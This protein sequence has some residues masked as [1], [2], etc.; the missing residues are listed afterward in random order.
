M[1]RWRFLVASEAVGDL[2][3]FVESFSRLK[4]G[5]EGARKIYARRYDRQG[6]HVSVTALLLW[7][8]AAA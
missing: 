7:A 5:A 4:T 3:V 8:G 1:T 2:L 6:A